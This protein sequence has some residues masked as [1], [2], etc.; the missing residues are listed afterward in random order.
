MTRN[1]D[2][3]RSIFNEIMEIVQNQQVVFFLYGYDG[4]G[5]RTTHS[6]FKISVPTLETSICNIDKKDEIA[7]LFKV[8]N[9]I[10]W[11]ETPMT[12]KFYFEVLDK[13]K[14]VV[15]GGD[16]GQILSVIPKEWI[17][18]IGDGTILESSDGYV[19][20]TIL[21]EFLISNFTDPIEVIVTS[22][23][24]D[25][26]NNYNDSN[27]LQNRAILTSTIEVIDDI[28]DYITKLILGEEN[29]CLSSDSIDK[30]ECTGF[31]AFEHLAP[32]FLNSI[33]ISRLP[34]NSIKLKIGTSIMLLRNL[35]DYAMVND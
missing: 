35:K 15:F 11:D 22:T 32:E 2:K 17:L 19:D 26:M 6:K 16:F 33:K 18:Q 27:L 25:L 3:Q 10:I 13:S 7:D 14:V 12:H 1:P 5:G 8:T 29:E 21:D 4:T 24:P 34:N 23:Y 31:D 20:I 30:S 28:N 9:I